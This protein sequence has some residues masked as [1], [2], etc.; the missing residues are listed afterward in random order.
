MGADVSLDLG[1]SMYSARRLAAALA[2]PVLMVSVAACTA[3][4]SRQDADHVVP[5]A[6]AGDSK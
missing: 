6:E 3:E 5:L 1:A 2:C 4:A